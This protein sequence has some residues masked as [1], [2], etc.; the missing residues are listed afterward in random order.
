MNLKE[1]QKLT[2]ERARAAGWYDSV[3]SPL[4]FYALVH[5]E[6]S[7]AVEEARKPHDQPP[8]YYDPHG[9]DPLKPE[10]EAIELADAVIRILDY[11]EFRGF[12][13]TQAIGIKMEYNQT[14]PHR[15][16]GK[17]F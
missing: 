17:R 15:H 3:R 16:G 10:G 4:E 14:R 11:C 5:S 12:D 6:I 9:K 2:H 7:E 13:L 8:I 1:L